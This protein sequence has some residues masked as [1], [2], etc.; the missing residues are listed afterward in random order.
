MCSFL[1]RSPVSQYATGPIPRHVAFEMDG[2]RRFARRTGRP[3][4]EGHTDGF[5]TFKKTIAICMCLNIRCVTVYVFAIDNFHRPSEEVDAIMNMVAEK[6]VEMSQKGAFLSQHGIRLHVLGHRELL[7]SHVQAAVE[8]AEELTRQNT[9]SIL[10]VCIP[11]ASRDEITLAV[12]SVVQQALDK[13]SFDSS[14]ITEQSIDENLMTTLTGSPP[15]DIFVRT[16][17]A[18]RLSGFLLW[19]CCENTQI[20]MVDTSWPEFGLW[21][22]VPIILDYQRKVWARSSS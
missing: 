10:N 19:Q 6:L 21:D 11:Y 20:H 1:R 15:L 9:R 13:E 18:K 16:S 3:V 17:G 12:Q 22:F 4:T 8:I 5:Y 7:P 14:L 2:N